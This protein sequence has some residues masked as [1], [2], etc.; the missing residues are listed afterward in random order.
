MTSEKKSR[1]SVVDFLCKINTEETGYFFTSYASPE[2][3]EKWALEAGIERPLVMQL[4]NAAE[5]LV[6]G[7]KNVERALT[8]IREAFDITEEE[9]EV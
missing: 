4:R 1:D 3:V 9:V 8:E 5:S 2:Q 7:H 6:R